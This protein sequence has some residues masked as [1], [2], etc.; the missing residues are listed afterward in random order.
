VSDD[1][2]ILRLFEACSN[3]GRW[4]PD[5][6]LGTLNFITPAKRVAAA[7]LLRDGRAIAL[8]RPLRA[9]AGVL[10]GVPFTH[11]MLLDK[12][13]AT[14]AL[15]HIG[16]TSHDPEITHV[17]AVTH[18]FWEGR[19]YNG[20][21]RDAI[22]SGGGLGFGSVQAQRHGIFTRG[23]LLDVAAAR[24]VAWLEDDAFVEPE[25]LDAAEAAQRVTVE[26]G[27]A[28]FLHVGRYAREAAN[29]GGSPIVRAG[30]HA[31]AVAWL[32]RREV[33]VYAGDCTERLPY[34]N[35]RFPLPLHQIGLVQ[36]GLC[37]LDAPD[38][39]ELRSALAERARWDFLL[40]F[41]PLD[42]PG[43]TGAPVNPTA[44]L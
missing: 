41:A 40:T 44:L 24:G 43:G 31:R 15:D 6:E 17:D 32:H 1:A 22:L 16:I 42:I 20:R 21:R 12:P 37:M 8:G 29:P 35:V 7:A 36:M 39:D 5:D 9:G 28:L 26:P 2:E 11:R 25:D 27:D 4:G 10:G 38:I 23:V 19:A 3:E 14:A 30:L 33:A 34:P 13:D 18:V